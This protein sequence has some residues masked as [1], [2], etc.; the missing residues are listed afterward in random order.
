MGALISLS[1]NLKTAYLCAVEADYKERNA[2]GLNLHLTARFSDDVLA[3]GP[4]RIRIALSRAY[5]NFQ[6]QNCGFPLAADLERE[7]PRREKV[8][9]ITKKKTSKR[10]VDGDQVELKASATPSL[11]YGNTAKNEIASIQETR[12]ETVTT[13]QHVF[14]RGGSEAPS[15]VFDA[16]PSQKFLSGTLLNGDLVGSIEPKQADFYD[17]AI[18]LEIPKSGLLLEDGG[19][20]SSYPNKKGLM[21]IAV[22][23]ALCRQ[24]NRL[25][26]NRFPK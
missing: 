10:E 23:L 16:Q 18:E 15:L 11:K 4:F 8:K 6:L 26:Q 2:P 7:W 3:L 1:T 24:P 20:L 5:L 17:I 19:E 22:A 21:K 12:S 14:W 25:R 13:W 9:T